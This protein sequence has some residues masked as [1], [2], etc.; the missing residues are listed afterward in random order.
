VKVIV[1][2]LSKK[3]PTDIEKAIKYYSILNVVDNLNLTLKQVELLA[4][5]S[6]RGTI[7]SPSARQEFITM[8]D[9]TLPSLENIKNK[10][11][12]RGWLVEVDRKYRV[13]PKVNL[14]FSRDIVLQINLLS[15]RS[16]ETKG[17]TSGAD[18]PK[19]G[20]TTGNSRESVRPSVQRVVAQDVAD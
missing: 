1:Q 8:F 14:D 3:I 16:S 6:V 2:K 5:T 19:T 17:L 4:F 11:K 13:N 9:S 12:R 15:A 10:L 7:T 20:D 18:S